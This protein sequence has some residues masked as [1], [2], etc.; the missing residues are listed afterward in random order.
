MESKDPRD[1]KINAT[2][3]EPFD[4]ERTI[5][6][7]HFLGQEA[8]RNAQPAVP[9][10]QINHKRTWPTPL[11]I[12]ALLF[13]LAAG[14][15]ASMLVLRSGTQPAQATVPAQPMAEDAEVH[16]PEQAS[17]S[18]ETPAFEP[19]R[20]K[21]S[22]NEMERPAQ[23]ASNR[24]N[25]PTE[26]REETKEGEV[27]QAADGQDATALRGALSEWVAAT[28]ARDIDKQMG[29]YNTKVDAF[30]LSRN[31]S[32]EDVRAEK[33]RVFARAR[34]I[35]VRAAEPQIRVSPDGNAATMRFRKKYAIEGSGQDR[36]GE[37]V[38]ELRWKRVGGQWRIVSER[39]VKVIGK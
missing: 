19:A 2:D 8:T 25:A 16:T 20:Q 17:L 30:Y 12:V 3:K 34:V 1:Q 32:R 33:A 6:T 13:G 4:A 10:S 31:A 26:A 14:T 27:I 36:R 15:F 39:D 35:D 21:A 11:I 37:V 9:L 23:M 22:A 38:Q 7:P 28:N 29:F 24:D 5:V 18:E